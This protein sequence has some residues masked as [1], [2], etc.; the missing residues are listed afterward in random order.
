MVAPSDGELD[1]CPGSWLNMDMVDNS[2]M[3][4]IMAM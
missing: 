4:I 1:K 3:L 2:A